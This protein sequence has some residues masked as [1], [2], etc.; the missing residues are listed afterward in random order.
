MA[1]S[2]RQLARQRRWRRPSF[3]LALTSRT[4]QKACQSPAAARRH[5]SRLNSHVAV[6]EACGR[7][8]LSGLLRTSGLRLADGRDIEG[9]E[10]QL[11]AGRSGVRGAGALGH[12]VLEKG[13]AELAPLAEPLGE[14]EADVEQVGRLEG[15][16]GLEALEQV[17][18]VVA[19]Q[20]VEERQTGVGVAVGAT[21]SLSGDLQGDDGSQVLR[22][23]RRAAPAEENS[24]PLTAG[25]SA[26]GPDPAAS[27]PGTAAWG[28]VR[29][30][31]WCP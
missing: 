21:E 23:G 8:G 30:G 11:V 3:C 29:P 27:R 13:A 17:K 26:A 6:G 15:A 28:R 16:L 31:R 7:A 9:F 12:D 22:L 5:F 2:Y 25:R 4:C 10:P 24:V 19:E 18:R 1:S 14:V 20:P